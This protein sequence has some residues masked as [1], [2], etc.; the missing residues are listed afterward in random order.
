MRYL[1]TIIMMVFLS[2]PAY[3]DPAACRMEGPHN[4]AMQNEDMLL[5]LTHRTIDHMIQEHP[6]HAFP[7]QNDVI[8][9]QAQMQTQHDTRHVASDANHTDKGHSGNFF[10]SLAFWR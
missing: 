2:V 7:T 4:C 8:L 1:L 9:S 5:A 10:A 3:A 6:E